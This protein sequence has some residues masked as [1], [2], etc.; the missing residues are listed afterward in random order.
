MHKLLEFTNISW[1]GFAKYP[2]IGSKNH[3]FLQISCRPEI[4]VVSQLDPPCAVKLL[5]TVFFAKVL[6]RR[7]NSI[8][9]YELCFL[10]RRCYWK[11]PIFLPVKIARQGCWEMALER[12]APLYQ[13]R[14]CLWPPW[15]CFAGPPRWVAWPACR[16]DQLGTRPLLGHGNLETGTLGW[17]VGAGVGPP[18]LAVPCLL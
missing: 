10:R 1:I 3:W 12:L 16:S 4:C 13:G 2:S 5:F 6:F 9:T 18:G 14:L 8:Q 17:L 7:I 11:A 15:P